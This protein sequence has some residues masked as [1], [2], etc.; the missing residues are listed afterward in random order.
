MNYIFI[1]REE[2]LFLIGVNKAIF[3][4]FISQEINNIILIILLFVG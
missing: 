4:F 1:R 2:I 3:N